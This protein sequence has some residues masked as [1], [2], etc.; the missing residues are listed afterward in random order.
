MTYA[1]YWVRQPLAPALA[2]VVAYRIFNFLLAATPGLIAN[3]QLQTI[4]SNG[5][6]R[7]RRPR[8]PELSDQDGR[9][10]QAPARS[11]PARR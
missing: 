2:A 10:A 5:S 8:S 7:R 6:A 1:L 11:G 9:P 4:I 3:Q